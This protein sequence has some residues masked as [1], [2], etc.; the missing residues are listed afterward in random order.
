MLLSGK[1]DFSQNQ[2]YIKGDSV[3][4]VYRRQEVVVYGNRD[5]I[6]SSMVIELDQQQMKARNST[7]VSELLSFE[8][9]LNLTSG[10]KSETEA[11]IRGFRSSDVLV[12]VGGRPINPGYYGKEKYHAHIGNR[13]PF[14]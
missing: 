9:G 11:R 4:Q 5:R 7:T 6:P 10:Y 3:F 13:L 1:S 8:P 14:S 12:L 2:Y